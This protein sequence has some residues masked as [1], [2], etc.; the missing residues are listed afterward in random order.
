MKAMK[1]HL[2][3]LFAALPLLA[4]ATTAVV[5]SR[6]CWRNEGAAWQNPSG[7]WL[8]HYN[9][10]RLI[11]AAS[12]IGDTRAGLQFFSNRSFGPMIWDHLGV[13]GYAVMDL[14]AACV[15]GADFHTN[16]SKRVLTVPIWALLVF[17]AVWAFSCGL[18]FLRAYAR[19]PR[20]V[21]SYCGYDLRGTPDRCPECGTVAQDADSPSEV[22]RL[23]SQT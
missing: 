4:S 1:R 17:T 8:L 21:C 16:D 2:F 12:T 20:G 15:P 10:G 3:H 6:S 14:Q 5:L 19:R 9:R 13:D 22:T 7:T 23:R 11:V 18:P